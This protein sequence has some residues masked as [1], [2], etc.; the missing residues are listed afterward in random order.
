MVFNLRSLYPNEFMKRNRL[1]DIKII[2]EKVSSLRILVVEDEE[3]IRVPMC[4][5]MGRFFY[6][7]VCAENGEDALKKY[8]EL[9]PFGI[10]FTDNRMP[11]MTGWELIKEL[12]RIDEKLF[13]AI[14]SGDSEDIRNDLSQCNIVMEKPNSFNA[15][16]EMLAKMI[17]I[18]KL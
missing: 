7:V 17:E 9:G 2:K 16:L 3:L 4:D 8:H 10:V 5:F 12:R 1:L 11:K 18:K 6:D 13:I 15:L 14:T